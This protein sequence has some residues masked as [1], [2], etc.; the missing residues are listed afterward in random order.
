MMTN[1]NQLHVLHGKYEASA[2]RFDQY[3]VGDLVEIAFI[4]RSNVGKSSLLNSLCRHHGLARVSG[5][6]GKTQTLNF[7][8]LTVKDIEEIRRELFLVDLPGYGYA[9]TGQGNRKQWAKF[10][11]EFLLKS[12]RLQMVCQLIDSRHSPMASDVATYQWLIA[13]D[14]RVQVIATKCDKLSR[15]T[16]PKQLADIRKKLGV[17]DG[18]VLPYSSAKGQGREEL[19]DLI[20]Q[21][22]L[23]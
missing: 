2:V 1:H 12:P 19:L 11:E 9:R 10:I 16:L 13:N 20:G 8:R 14:L 18:P 3:P 5:T 22:L 6:P 21:I 4:G 15:Q 17:K 7:Y 23:K